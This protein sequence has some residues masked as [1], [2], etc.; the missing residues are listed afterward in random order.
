MLNLRSQW[1]RLRS[2]LWFVPS[3]LVTGAVGPHAGPGRDRRGR[4]M[5]YLQDRGRGVGRVARLPE[6]IR[7]RPSPMQAAAE[8]IG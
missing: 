3:L 7:Q 8:A 5:D 2:S 4:R 6:L 1:D